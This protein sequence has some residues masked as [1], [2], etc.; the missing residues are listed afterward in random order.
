VAKL[1]SY[2]SS[3]V[4]EGCSVNQAF[5][6]VLWA[7]GLIPNTAQIEVIYLESHVGG[8]VVY[9]WADFTWKLPYFMYLELLLAAGNFI[10]YRQDRFPLV[11][12]YP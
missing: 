10:D 6:H 11:S 9:F 8:L 5:V 12:H 1:R 3:L 7:L 4:F 2:F